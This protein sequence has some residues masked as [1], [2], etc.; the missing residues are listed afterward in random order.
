MFFDYFGA[1]WGLGVFYSSRKSN[2]DFISREEIQ[3][4]AFW[5]LQIKLFWFVIV[6][7]WYIHIWNIWNIW[8]YENMQYIKIHETYMKI[9]KYVK[10]AIYRARLNCFLYKIVIFRC[11]SKSIAHDSTFFCTQMWYLGVLQNLS[12]TIHFC[13]YKMASNIDLQL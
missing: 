4:E 7:I 6:F 9:W 12:R 10:Y 13:L 1:F 3:F 8:K 11:S 5:I 2:Y